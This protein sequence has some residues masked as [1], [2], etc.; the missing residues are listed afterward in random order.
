MA[1]KISKAVF[2]ELEEFG[3]GGRNKIHVEFE[4]DS[5]E[6]VERNYDGDYY[7]RLR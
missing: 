5:Y 7:S 3:R 6:N 2:S 4:F 1:L